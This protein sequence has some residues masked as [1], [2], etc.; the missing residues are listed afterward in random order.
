MNQI[1]GLQ[2]RIITVMICCTFLFAASVLFYFEY[3]IYMQAID[4]GKNLNRLISSKF[5]V[6]MS[7]HIK[8]S[9]KIFHDFSEIK[10]TLG[11]AITLNSFEEIKEDVDRYVK[12]PEFNEVIIITSGNRIISSSIL[13]KERKEELKKLQFD[14]QELLI[15]WDKE[16]KTYLYSQPLY[17]DDEYLGMILAYLDF[18]KVDD[19]LRDYSLLFIDY[20]INGV[21]TFLKSSDFFEGKSINVGYLDLM[22]SFQNEGFF[23]YLERHYITK[24]ALPLPNG[25]TGYIGCFVPEYELMKEVYKIG[26]ISGITTLVLL[27]I[28]IILVHLTVSRMLQPLT[29]L[30]QLILKSSQNIGKISKESSSVGKQLFTMVDHQSD[31]IEKT[32]IDLENLVS[33]A[34]QNSQLASKAN[35]V[36][37]SSN[38]LAKQGQKQMAFIMESMSKLISYAKDTSEVVNV[39]KQISAQIDIVAINASIEAARAGSNGKEFAHVAQQV[40]DLAQNSFVQLERVTYEIE[41]TFKLLNDSYQSID[42][43]KVTLES[44]VEQVDQASQLMEKL[45]LG[46]KSQRDAMKELNFVLEKLDQSTSENQHIAD[47]TS[48]GGVSLNEA[49]I[50]LGDVVLTLSS[51]LGI[52]F[53]YTF[54]EMKEKSV[55]KEDEAIEV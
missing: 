30:T 12:E 14:K 52:D 34:N 55:Y 29:K 17:I 20:D 25:K 3:E 9:R 27:I 50:L 5:H 35:Q 13:E 44:I 15:Q 40:G 4:S 37:Y 26:L 2:S 36:I 16:K 10:K 48:K 18:S 7:N 24:I 11:F 8:H 33:I 6:S 32:Y 23:H 31:F 28:A 46:S 38:K 51:I 22:N 21:V 39:I 45:T 41:S 47:K 42:H 49:S 43:E 1:K 53:R 19:L 54:E